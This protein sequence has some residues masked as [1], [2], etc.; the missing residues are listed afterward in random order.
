M[1]YFSKQTVADIVA[2]I[3]RIVAQLH[4]HAAA[5]DTI[6]AKHDALVSHHEVQRGNA[7]EE[8]F[9]ATAQ[10]ERIGRLVG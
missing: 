3:T 2:P 4:E 6:A 1:G 5:H 7:N 10:A 9:L 8:S